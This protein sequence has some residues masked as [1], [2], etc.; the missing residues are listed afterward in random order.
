MVNTNEDSQLKCWI[1][2]SDNPYN[3]FTHFDEWKA[4]DELNDYNTCEYLARITNV[5]DEL[6]DADYDN[7][8]ERSIDEIIKYNPLKIYIKVKPEEL[9]N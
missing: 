8:I 5:S 3:P 9:V 2:T 1:T 7:E 4:Y 6:S